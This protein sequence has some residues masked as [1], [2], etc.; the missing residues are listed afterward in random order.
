MEA[1]SH[2]RLDLRLLTVSPL[3]A[4]SPTACG[5]RSDG[6]YGRPADACWRVFP[7]RRS[8]VSGRVSR[9]G[10][11]RA[12]SDSVASPLQLQCSSAVSFRAKGEGVDRDYQPV[13]MT[14]PAWNPTRRRSDASRCPTLCAPTTQRPQVYATLALREPVEKLASEIRLADL[15]ALP[16]AGPVTDPCHR[17][18]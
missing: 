15:L 12:V 11:R 16:V 13:I 4:S 18:Q 7:V 14:S 5:L 9:T 2:I 1:A 8:L 17:D 3:P 10:P 6:E